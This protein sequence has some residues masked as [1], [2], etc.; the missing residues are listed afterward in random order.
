MNAEF[1]FRM[2]FWGLFVILL[3]IR[4]V[5]MAR[6]RRAG[7]A[8]MPDAQAIQQEGKGL[9]AVRLATWFLMIGWLVCYAIYPA[10]M[11]YL[12]IA[13]QPWMRW[14]GFILGLGSLALL[15]W[16]Q[17]AL[18]TQFSPQLRLQAG[19]HLVTNGPYARVRHPMYSSLFGLG[20]AFALV[21]ANWVF[22]VLALVV[23]GGLLAR[24][25]REEQMMLV[26]FGDDYREYMRRTRKYF[27]R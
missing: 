6:V 27:P 20:A 19:H 4:V 24:V 26:E 14:F 21:T 8:V 15:A 18:G 2:A 22:V 1:V 23:I 13:L 10:W 11:V 5:S 17:A 3:V 16:T 25:P 12:Q 9:F 7:K